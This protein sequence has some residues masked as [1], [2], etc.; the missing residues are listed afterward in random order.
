MATRRTYDE[1]R[2]LSVNQRQ[3]GTSYG[4]LT[5]HIKHLWLDDENDNGYEPL[6]KALNT[7]SLENGTTV[8]KK[9][10]AIACVLI[11]EHRDQEF[12]EGKIIKT[13]VLN[14]SH[15]ISRH[16]Y[17]HYLMFQQLVFSSDFPHQI[18]QAMAQ[19]NLTCRSSLCFDLFSHGVRGLFPRIFSDVSRRT[20]S[21]S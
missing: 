21:E 18:L 6:Q 19:V 3:I 11:R 12:S 15:L 8:Y 1:C 2:M 9:T 20:K 16:H 17:I 5:R 7:A 13:W 4:Q 14:W 10:P